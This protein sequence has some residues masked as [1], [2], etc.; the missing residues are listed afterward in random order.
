[1]TCCNVAITD[2]SV[3]VQVTINAGALKVLVPDVV[4]RAFAPTSSR[5]CVHTYR[6]LK[7]VSIT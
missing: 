4:T 5:E 1:M 3:I 7:H 6:C 2:T